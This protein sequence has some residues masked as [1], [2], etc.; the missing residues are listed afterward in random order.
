MVAIPGGVRYL[1]RSEATMFDW[2]FWR[3]IAVLARVSLWTW[4]GNRARTRFEEL[5]EMEY[6]RGLLIILALLAIGTCSD[7][8][9][10]YAWGPNAIIALV[11][12]AGRIAAMVGICMKNTNGWWMA[13]SFFA[14]IILLSALAAANTQNPRTIVMAIV[15]AGCLIYLVGIKSEFE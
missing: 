13:V 12:L 7:V 6:P 15:P 5:G 3:L 14:V 10:V 9:T 4:V 2:Q 8:F 1:G 11:L